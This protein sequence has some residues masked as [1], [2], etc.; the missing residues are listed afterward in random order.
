VA[1]IARPLP[2]RFE[3][4]LADGSAD[5]RARY[6]RRRSRRDA[7]RAHVNLNTAQTLGVTFAQPL[8]MRAEV[9]RA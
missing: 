5:V 6:R 8:L 4:C 9:I 3:R 7:R 1:T 2:Q